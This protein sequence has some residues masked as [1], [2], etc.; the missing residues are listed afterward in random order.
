MS[1]E[2]DTERTLSSVEKTTQIIHALEGLGGAGVKQLSNEL[3][4]PPSTVHAH[5]ATLENT[6]FV[7]TEGDRYYLSYEFVRFGEHARTRKP[8]FKEVR[9]RLPKLANETECRVQFAVEHRGRGIYLYTS[10]PDS[11]MQVYSDIGKT[12]PL[13]ASAAGKAL[14]AHLPE[15]YIQEIIDHHG[16]SKETENTI[17]DQEELLN[18]LEQVREEGVAF[19]HEEHISGLNAVGGP[20]FGRD[21]LIAGSISISGPAN[22]LKSDR[23]ET[24]LRD[25]VLG[26]TNEIELTL[27]HS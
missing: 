20:V 12:T 8:I 11:L 27:T 5:L 16:L 14:L 25:L 17:T 4:F 24:E 18:E 6:G 2:N 21:S 7:M 1:L 3:D 22:R 9:E 19:N 23:L 13:H 26:T 15:Q 10:A